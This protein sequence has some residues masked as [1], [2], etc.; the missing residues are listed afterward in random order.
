MY[1]DGED[2]KKT[3]ARMIYYAYQSILFQQG[4]D[5]EDARYL[6]DVIW[7]LTNW[8]TSMER[9]VPRSLLIIGSVGSGKTT[10]VA[11]LRKAMDKLY[12]GVPGFPMA[13]SVSIPCKAYTQRVK[14]KNDCY[15]LMSSFDLMIFDDLGA[16]EPVVNDFGTL[17]RP[18]ET[19]VKK[20]SDEHKA[21]V[22]TTNLTID[23]IREQYQSER[24]AD[25]LRA[26]AILEMTH[27][28]FRRI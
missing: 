6:G 23:A 11:A 24:M 18:M 19:V 4:K 27:G 21:V 14:E 7:K 26:Y 5:I 9:N 22:I 13:T 2:L 1:C 17:I 8:L 16:E 12:E 15:E 28:S 25:C 10:L 3:F 20:A